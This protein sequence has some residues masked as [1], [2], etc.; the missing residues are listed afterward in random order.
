MDAKDEK[1]QTL[2]EVLRDAHEAIEP[3]DSWEAL[4]TR[5]AAKLDSRELP[6]V[7][8]ILMSKSAVLWR[9]IAMVMAACL[10]VMT[11]LLLYMV[12]FPED[13]TNAQ[14]TGKGLLTRA[15]LDQ[16]SATFSQVRQLFD[17]NSPWIVVGSGDDAEMGVASQPVE[18]GDSDKVVI[19]RL[20]VSRDEYSAR[21][22]YFDIVA[23]SNQRASLQIPMN[24]VSI[25]RLSLKPMLGDNDEVSVEIDAQI[26]GGPLSTNTE[27]IADNAFTSLLRIQSNGKRV[28]ISAVGQLMPNI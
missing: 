4:R 19:V 25:L 28:D 6:L 12:G 18:T 22:R 5:V 15:Q 21:R 14:N 17:E 13:H 2:G 8:T 9:R 7:Q 11:G 26:N 20:L 16:L 27:A 24:D 23:F 1:E 3:Q 10:L